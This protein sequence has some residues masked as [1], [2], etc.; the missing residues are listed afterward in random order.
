MVQIQN[1]SFPPNY[2]ALQPHQKNL[3]RELLIKKQFGF[4]TLKN[5]HKKNK[6][7]HK[8]FFQNIC[9]HEQS[10]YATVKLV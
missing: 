4:A 1:A 6:N 9:S 3:G 5:A 2:H 8:G 10:Y 7:A